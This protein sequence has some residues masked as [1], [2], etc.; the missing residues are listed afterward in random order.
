MLLPLLSLTNID[1]HLVQPRQIKKR[2]VEGLDAW[3][4]VP[5]NKSEM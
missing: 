2:I 1:F 5:I 4:A 3:E